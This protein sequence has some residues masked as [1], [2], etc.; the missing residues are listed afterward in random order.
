MGKYTIEDKSHRLWCDDLL[1]RF[2]ETLN[3]DIRKLMLE[4]PHEELSLTENA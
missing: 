4:G 2:S 1:H 3:Q